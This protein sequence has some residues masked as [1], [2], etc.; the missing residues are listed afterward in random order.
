MTL[1]S[2]QMN[3]SAAERR[4][5]P[6]FGPSGKLAMGW[7]CWV[8]Q[9]RY[10]QLE[11]IFD[12]FAATRVRLLQ[13]WCENQWSGLQSVAQHLGDDIAAIDEATLL[14]L[15]NKL[16]DAS[17]LFLLDST[18]QPQCSSAGQL[19]R[20]AWHVGAF[21]LRWLARNQAGAAI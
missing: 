10:A 8:N 15:R 13:Q 19:G 5:L 12:S 11:S 14:K 4:W 6:W 2:D 1:R 7:A 17:E 9:N 16:P 3:L 21:C 20:Q 18:G